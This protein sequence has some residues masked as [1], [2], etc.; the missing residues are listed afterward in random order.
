MLL[1]PYVALAIIAGFIVALC[2]V[3]LI[4][5]RVI[6]TKIKKE[7]KTSMPVGS[8]TTMTAQ[9]LQDKYRSERDSGEFTRN[10]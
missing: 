7:S 5:Y 3:G 6:A 4:V 10:I 1:D 9:M 2:V 8:D